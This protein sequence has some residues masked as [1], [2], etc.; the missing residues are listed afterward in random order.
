MIIPHPKRKSSINLFVKSKILSTNS[1]TAELIKL[2]ENAYRDV[3]IAFANELSVISDQFDIDVNEVIDIANQHPRVNIL[4]PGCGVG[5][6]CI[7][8][9]P[10]FIAS[11][12][13]E[14]T[15]LIQTARKVNNKKVDWV[16][17]KI[18]S[19]LEIL[20]KDRTLNQ[21]LIVGIFG[22]TYKPNID[23]L[24]ESPALK[25]ALSLQNLGYEVYCCDPNIEEHDLLNIYHMQEVLDKSNLSV[26]L[27]LHNEFKDLNLQNLNILDFCGVEDK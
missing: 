9:D 10:W 5:G 14:K 12:L 23:D 20:A 15:P 8:V 6:H 22:L 27:V 3:N 16:I 1:D 24:R 18:I 17:N 13:P 21:N 2:S 7:A 11:S 25:I 19:S 26:F 4:E